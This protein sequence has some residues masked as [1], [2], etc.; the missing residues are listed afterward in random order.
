MNLEEAKATFLEDQGSANTA[1][2]YDC[3]LRRFTDWM[4]SKGTYI[5]TIE[6]ID[7]KRVVDFARH[8]K[9]E[10]LSPRSVSSYLTSIVQFLRW[11]KREGLSSV[12]GDD[13]FMLQEQI[14]DW[15]KKNKSNPLPKLPKE[16]AVVTALEAAHAIDPKEEERVRLYHLR[17]A[18]LIELLA[19]TGCRISEAA[20]LKRANLIPDQLAAWVRGGKGR[21]DRMI[22]F[23]SQDSW[24]TVQ[25]YLQ[26]R[27]KLNHKVIG[28]EPLF[29]RHD[30]VAY[31]QEKVLPMTTGGMRTALS[32]LLEA[33]GVEHFSPH[34]LRHRAG[35]RELNKT[36][37]VAI[38][39]KFLG[40][41]DVSTTINTYTHLTYDDVIEAVRG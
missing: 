2:T 20:N 11:L 36:G 18:A 4:A 24:D 38:V 21:K 19:S 26:E 3:G 29:A 5:K 40:H 8:L 7:P 28:E 23:V 30:R 15:N 39:Q 17:N 12:S 37:N 13:L 14:K 35:T 25:L 16:K 27:D 33:A 22:V 32:L 6:D 41:K 1:R 31:G 10:G 9:R 34:K